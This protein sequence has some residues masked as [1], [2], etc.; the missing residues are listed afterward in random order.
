LLTDKN[1]VIK[2]FEY[3]S[4]LYNYSGSCVDGTI[5]FGNN[6]TLLSRYNRFIKTGMRKKVLKEIK[7]NLLD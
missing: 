7:E 4:K 6:Q 5:L 2:Q 1:I 3:T